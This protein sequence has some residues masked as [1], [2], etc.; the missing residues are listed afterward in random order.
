MIWCYFMCYG[1]QSSSNCQ[2]SGCLEDRKTHFYIV[3][4]V[5]VK[6]YS[7]VCTIHIICSKW[8]ETCKNIGIILFN[9]MAQLLYPKDSHNINFSFCFHMSVLHS[10]F[11]WFIVM[12]CTFCLF[13]P[14]QTSPGE[15][16]LRMCVAVKKKLQMYYWKD[17]EF[18]ELQ[19]KIKYIADVTHCSMIQV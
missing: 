4:T 18:H 7:K 5:C 16:R 1:L 8:A 9:Y 13:C 11:P 17:R 3:N 2:V 6:I 19:V 14:Q 10:Y 15:E 12:N